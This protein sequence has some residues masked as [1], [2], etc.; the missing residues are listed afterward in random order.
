[1]GNHESLANRRKKIVEQLPCPFGDCSRLR[2]ETPY[3]FL[4]IDP[5]AERVIPAR[6]RAIHDRDMT[7]R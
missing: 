5:I 3:L 4:A 7:G 2:K 1:M 6:D